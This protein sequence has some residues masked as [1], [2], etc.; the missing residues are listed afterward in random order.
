[1]QHSRTCKEIMVILYHI[2]PN[3]AT[4]L[5]RSCDVIKIQ[6]KNKKNPAVTFESHRQLSDCGRFTGLLE[7]KTGHKVAMM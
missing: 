1:M 3:F 7:I 4:C 2:W 5:H 6:F